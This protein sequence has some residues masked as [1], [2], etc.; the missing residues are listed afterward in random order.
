VAQQLVVQGMYLP[1]VMCDTSTQRYRV[2]AQG[3]F[4][5]RVDVKLDTHDGVDI[6]GVQLDA[7]QNAVVGIERDA[8]DSERYETVQIMVDG[9]VSPETTLPVAG[10]LTVWTNNDATPE[11]VIPIVLEATESQSIQA[12][13]DKFAFGVIEAGQRIKRTSVISWPASQELTVAKV[14][15]SLPQCVILESKNLPERGGRSSIMISCELQPQEHNSAID[16]E[17]RV[18]LQ[19][20]GAPGVGHTVTLPASAFVKDVSTL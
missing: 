13:P 15:S 5:Y 11:I 14:T 17:V 9:T 19:E 6:I 16:A 18:V 4:S 2:D 3:K 12:S 1:P 10:Q 8:G 7:R 20:E